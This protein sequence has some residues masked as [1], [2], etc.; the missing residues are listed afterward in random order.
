MFYKKKISVKKIYFPIVIFS[1][2]TFISFLINEGDVISFLSSWFKDYVR[3]F[4]IFLAMINLDFPEKKIMKI[5]KALWYLLLLQVPIV[6]LQ[7]IWSYSHWKAINEGDIRQDYIAGMLGGR[8]TIELGILLTIGISALFILFLNKKVKLAYFIIVFSLFIAVISIAEIKFAFFLI[9]LSFSIIFL[10]NFN[11]KSSITLLLSGII[12]VVG[13]QQL[14]KLYPNFQNFLS[15][16]NII[17][18]VNEPYAASRIARS[19]SFIIAN[20]IITKDFS[21]TILGY[22]AGNADKISEMYRFS[23]FNVSQYITELGYIGVICFYGVFIYMSIIS[24]YLIKN[25]KRE[26]EKML[27]TIG[28]ILQVIIILTTF[29]NMPMVNITFS[30]F[31][32]VTNGVIYRYYELNKNKICDENNFENNENMGELI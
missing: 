9:A 8:G 17:S 12:I 13:M 3:Y 16:E 20:E 1:I 23:A 24:I 29:Y 25:G 22:G 27:G 15:K 18:Y 19:N 6:F 21:T 7:D 14:I 4:V 11:L 10:I 5:I 30:V 28:L 2:S 26:F 31:A 32:W